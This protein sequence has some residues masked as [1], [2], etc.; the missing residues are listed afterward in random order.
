M[1]LTGNFL[2]LRRADAGLSCFVVPT[3]LLSDLYNG[4]GFTISRLSFDGSI[5]Y[6]VADCSRRVKMVE[7]GRPRRMPEAGRALREYGLGDGVLKG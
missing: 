6:R 4:R 1:H 2:T 5:I 3:R 7:A